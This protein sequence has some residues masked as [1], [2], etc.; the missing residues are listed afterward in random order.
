MIAWLGAADVR[1]IGA[2]QT[3]LRLNYVTSVFTYVESHFRSKPI[4]FSKIS[5]FR[6]ANQ[7]SSYCWSF[8]GQNCRIYVSFG[9]CKYNCTV[10]GRLLY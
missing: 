8:A 4:S 6:L 1:N 10:P 5:I 7:E 2:K 3:Y 9:S